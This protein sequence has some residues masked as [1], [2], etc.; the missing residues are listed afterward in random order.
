MIEEYKNGFFKAFS[1][2]FQMEQ[3]SKWVEMLQID[4]IVTATLVME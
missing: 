4:S 2:I 1:S 3:I